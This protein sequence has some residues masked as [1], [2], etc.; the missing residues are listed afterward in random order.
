MRSYHRKT[1]IISAILAAGFVFFLLGL[2]AG[3]VRHAAAAETVNGAPLPDTGQTQSYTSTF[4]EDSDYLIN[5][6]AYTKL[7]ASGNDLPDS[8][9]EWV[10]VRDNVTGLIWEVKTD[11]GSIHDKDDTYTWQDAQDVFIA[12]VN[13]EQFG[14]H[15]DWRIPTLKELASITDLGRYN[16]A[17]NR[18]Y[19]PNTLSSYYWSSTTNAYVT[20]YAWYVDFRNGYG[21]S[22]NKS[23][24]YYAR[25]VRGGQ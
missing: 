16:P 15:S 22:S 21:S 20:D 4:G 3:S 7:D 25:A 6:P 9:T 2:G 23:N 14:G 11:D 18:D 8:A 13:A 10:M 24:S 12:A 19:F 17:I 1:V 5:P